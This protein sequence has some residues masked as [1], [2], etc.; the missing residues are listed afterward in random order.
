MN[1][2]IFLVSFLLLPLV[3][4][5]AFCGA[6]FDRIRTLAGEW[7]AAGPE[8]KIRVTFQLISDGTALMETMKAGTE[9]MVTVYHP[10]GESILM[11]HYCSGGNQP[12]MRARKSGGAGSITFQFVDVSNLKGSGDGHMRRLVIKFQDAD[13]VIEEWTWKEKGQENTS[14]FHLRRV[15]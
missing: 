6:D 5:N 7:E 9:N 8:E 2:M 1:K 12:R 15:K 10:D 14:T 4:G 3:N 11:T 13:N